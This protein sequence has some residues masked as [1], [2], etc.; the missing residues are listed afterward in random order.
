MGKLSTKDLHKYLDG[1]LPKSDIVRVEEALKGDKAA[2]KE[3]N[4]I[5]K[6]SSFVKAHL[7]EELQQNPVEDIWSGV[8]K[9]LETGAKPGVV[10]KLRDWFSLSNVGLFRPV[11]AAAGVAVVVLVVLWFFVWKG[12]VAESPGETSEKSKGGGNR[13]VV[14]SMDYSGPPPM[15]FQIQDGQGE[16]E[17]TMTVIWVNPGSTD[18]TQDPEDE[19]NGFTGDSI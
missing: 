2:E 12:T 5:K 4:S 7:E 14:E 10:Q 19:V 1:E 17:G 13:L 6:L 15:F 3:L 9:Q 8:S 16:D 11:A 18:T